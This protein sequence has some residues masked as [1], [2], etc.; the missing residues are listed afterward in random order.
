MK[1]LLPA[2]EWNGKK[3]KKNAMKIENSP[4]NTRN[5]VCVL[6]RVRSARK[7]SAILTRLNAPRGNRQQRLLSM[8]ILAKLRNYTDEFLT[9]VELVRETRNVSAGGS[10]LVVAISEDE[11]KFGGVEV[12]RISEYGRC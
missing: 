3:K 2:Q 10:L 12:A 4:W 8:Q 5:N 6:D 9:E 11:R 1:V 7:L